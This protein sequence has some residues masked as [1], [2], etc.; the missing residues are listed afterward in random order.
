[1]RRSILSAGGLCA[2]IG[3]FA[4]GQTPAP[5][6]VVSN[7][8]L[9]PVAP[10]DKKA[11][12]AKKDDKSKS[13]E[14]KT[15]QPKLPDTVPPPV[16]FPTTNNAALPSSAVAAAGAVA[17]R[18]T[19]PNVF[20]DRPVGGGIRGTMAV[21]LDALGRPIGFRP[22]FIL[23]NGRRVVLGTANQPPVDEAVFANNPVAPPGTPVARVIAVRPPEGAVF[24]P[25]QAD[26]VSRQPIAGYG[27][28]KITENESPRPTTRAYLTYNYYDD[29]FSASAPN[30]P[31]VGLH[32]EYAN[33]SRTLSIG[34]RLPYYQ[35]TSPGF[36][37]ET[38]L[39]AITIVT[40]AVVIENEETGSLISAGMTVTAPTGRR[41]ERSTV[42]GERVYSTLLQ[43]YLGFIA[44]RDDWFVQGFSSIIV[45]TD[46]SDVTFLSNDVQLG[47]LL[48]KNEGAFLS[49]FTPVVEAHLNT[50][51]NHRGNRAEPVGFSDNLTLL[52]GFQ[53]TFV[54]RATLGF[55]VGAPVNGPRP[56][57]LQATCQFNLRF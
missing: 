31:R 38:G 6:P 33:A 32:L 29:L 49:G 51:L 26:R 35:L 42:T 17:A 24:A 40:K 52:G 22:T 16:T 21:P 46:S 12:D 20:G 53:L 45:P 34:A 15:G 8:V 41:P 28:F 57:S 27:A 4:S 14:P 55:V 36:Y 48:Y 25:E 30:T 1:M 10:Q 37:N 7:G 39:G 50:P 18:T 3:T 11:D 13:A 5:Q 43:P 47:Y 54:D 23:P 9:I 19:Q 56:Y 44:N 2:L